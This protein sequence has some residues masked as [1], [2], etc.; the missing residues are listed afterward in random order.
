MSRFEQRIGFFREPKIEPSPLL[1]VK[2]TVLYNN[3]K[4]IN[5]AY[6]RQFFHYLAIRSCALHRMAILGVTVTAAVNLT[7]L[8]LFD[9]G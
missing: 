5:S 1:K 6:P 7:T 3:R 9:R 2:A 4:G 8:S